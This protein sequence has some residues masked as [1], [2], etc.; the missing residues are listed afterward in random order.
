MRED[1]I[2]SSVPK[3]DEPL[4]TLS[5]C[6][7]GQATFCILTSEHYDEK[8]FVVTGLSEHLSQPACIPLVKTSLFP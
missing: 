4:K 3:S 1:P 6:C 5:P 2:T 7:L 8:L